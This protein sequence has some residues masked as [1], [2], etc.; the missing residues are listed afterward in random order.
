[1]GPSEVFTCPPQEA[2]RKPAKRGAKENDPSPGSAPGPAQASKARW[3]QW[4][5]GRQLGSPT[6][7]ATAAFLKRP[8]GTKS[9]WLLASDQS[10]Q[11]GADNEITQLKGWQEHL[12]G[13]CHL[14]VCV[15]VCVCVYGHEHRPEP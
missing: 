11:D 10:E 6:G 5:G 8:Q 13:G 14:C 15:C 4:E 1:M 12:V 3:A 9:I 2:V 7:S